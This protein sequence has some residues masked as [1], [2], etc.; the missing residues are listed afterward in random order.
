VTMMQ[1]KDKW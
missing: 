1:T